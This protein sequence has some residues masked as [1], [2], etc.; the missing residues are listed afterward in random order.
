MQ[1]GRKALHIYSKVQGITQN[2]D[3]KLTTNTAREITLICMR[4]DA[5]P[6]Q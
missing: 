2:I 4:K 3:I 1:G 6:K 5:K